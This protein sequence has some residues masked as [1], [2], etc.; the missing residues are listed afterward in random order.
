MLPAPARPAS[1][2]RDACR[3]G[4]SRSTRAPLRESGS[5][6]PPARERSNR[7]R[8]RRGS[9]APAIRIRAP[10]ANSISI[11]PGPTTPAGAASGAIRTGAKLIGELRPQ[12]APPAVQLAGVDPGFPSQRRHARTRLQRRRYQLLLLRRTPASPALN[13]CDDLDPPVRHVTIPVNSHMTHTLSSSARRP[14]PEGYMCSP[15]SMITT[16]KRSISFC[17]ELE[18]RAGQTCRLRHSAAFTGW[19]RAKIGCDKQKRRLLA[20]AGVSP[21]VVKSLKRI[22]LSLAGLAVTYSPRA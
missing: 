7:R 6:P 13:R 17:P 3:C 15:V 12:L 21:L 19:A 10:L 22:R 8:Q 20:E 1:S 4:P 5:S 9:T 2:C 18:G 16:S 14:L 11:V